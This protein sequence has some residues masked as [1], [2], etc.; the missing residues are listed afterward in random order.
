M[1]SMQVYES[2]DIG[3]AKPT[4]DERRRVRHHLLD[5]VA[6]SEDFTVSMFQDHLDDALSSI[7]KA[8]RC[9]LLVG[10]TGLYHRAA[11]DGLDL[12]GT[13]PDIRE[14]LEREAADHGTE[15]LY[16]RLQEQDA[17]AAEK[18]E[19]T[20][21]RRIVRALEVIEGSGTLFSSRGE[22]LDAYS[23]TE[24]HQVGLRWPRHLLADR[25]EHRV[26][27]MVAQG[28]LAEVAALQVSGLSRTA[29]QALG[30]KEFIDHLNGGCSL[31]AAVAQTITR[32]RQFAVRQDRWFRRDPRICWVDIE[33][34]P[35]K[36]VAPV[37]ERLLP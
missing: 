27:S 17:R 25:I 1:D 12:A 13:W 23:A 20:N 14:R 19:P 6:P 26:H 29:A 7:A 3:T 33:S 11:V 37:V 28:W 18:M 35:V 4:A 9:A 16:G 10:G 31:D 15:V 2:M 34:D 32:T 8:K 24:V 36:E 22:G 30:Y 5:L 21:T